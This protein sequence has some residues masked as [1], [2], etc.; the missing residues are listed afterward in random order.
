MRP[1]R[2]LGGHGELWGTAPRLVVVCHRSPHQTSSG[3]DYETFR[4]RVVVFLKQSVAEGVSCV[5][6]GAI[7]PP[8]LHDQARSWQNAIF[9][10]GFAGLHW[11]IEYGGQGFDRAATGIWTEECARAQVSPYLNLQGLILAGE[12]IQRAGS[13]DQKERFLQ[14]TLSG[15]MLWCQLFSEPDAGSDLASLT[16]SAT[17][18]GDHYVLNGQKVWTSNGQHAEFGILL[19]RTD[20][21]RLRHRG[22][23]F[24]LLDMHNP[25]VEVRPVIQM[26]G[27]AEFC[28]VFLQ[29][30]AVPTSCLLGPE[31]DG[32]R[33]T[34]E[35]LLD[36]RG[37]S[38]SASLINLER[39]LSQLASQRG[40]NPVLNDE[41]MKL[42]V[43]GHALRAML[44][45]S[46]GGV[47][48]ASAAKLMRTEFEFDLAAVETSLRGATAML[49]GSQT[50]RF[51][52]SP[53]MKIAGGTSEIQRNII[54]ERV[55]GLGRE[56]RA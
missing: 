52:Y 56:P 46:D 18:D 55:L 45:R 16:T 49:A 7:L 32:W 22:I 2:Y 40:S 8:H 20:P 31:N 30:V 10:A 24:F 17:R 38:G 36:E 51:L 37:T 35:V 28:E 1:R 41:L 25:G 14:P 27:E 3:V 42:Y 4:Q 12:A 33:V 6:Y 48:K 53:G 44:L 21:D 23:S 47:E 26:T 43:R 13:K 34:M 19:A 5:S 29:D 15:E 50:N 11:P 39:R 54:G 9:E